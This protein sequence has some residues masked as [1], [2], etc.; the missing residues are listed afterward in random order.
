[1][2]AD[3]VRHTMGPRAQLRM[4]VVMLAL[5]LAFIPAKPLFFRAEGWGVFVMS[6]LALVFAGVGVIVSAETLMEVASDVDELE[7]HAEK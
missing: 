6:A 4:G 1:M 7:E 3:W 2:I 5:G